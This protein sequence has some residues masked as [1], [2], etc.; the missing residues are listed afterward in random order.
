[1]RQGKKSERN[2][3]V[4]AGAGLLLWA[5]APLMG[6]TPGSQERHFN[7]KAHP[8]VILQNI[9][10][11]RIEVKSWKNAEVVVS[12]TSSDKVAVD[13]EQ[14]GDRIDINTSALAAST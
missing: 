4:M 3:L 11:G 6:A 7:V 12:S 9:V 2:V 8:V 10:N 13:V 5:G 1:M 14:V